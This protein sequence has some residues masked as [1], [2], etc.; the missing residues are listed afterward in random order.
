MRARGWAISALV[1]IS[2]VFG[3]YFWDPVLA[4]LNLLLMKLGALAFGGGFTLIPLIQQEVV[5]RLGWLSTREFIDGI[6]L[7]QVTPGPIMITATFVGYR[8]AG[9][10]GAIASTLAVFFPS[11]LV[12]VGA[13]PHFERIKRLQTVQWM[14]RGILAGFIGL[15]VFVLVQFGQASLVD[16][17]TWALAA[18]AFIALRWKVDLLVIV[19]AAAL[20]SIL[21]F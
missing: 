2:L 1:G 7:G 12:L 16:W 20:I 15:L 13:A 11:F 14:I 8:I 10:L 21:V 17:K 5:E 9:V 3:P 18:A 19:G 4:Q 6:A